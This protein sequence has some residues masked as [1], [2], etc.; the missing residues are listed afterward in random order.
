MN[1]CDQTTLL[2]LAMWHIRVIF[3]VFAVCTGEPVARP[4]RYCREH[5]YCYCH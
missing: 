4:D 1:R 5:Q 2:E 3:S